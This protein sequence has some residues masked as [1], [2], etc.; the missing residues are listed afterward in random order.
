M[1]EIRIKTS[2]TCSMVSLAALLIIITHCTIFIPV[3]FDLLLW[4]HSDMGPLNIKL[5]K[6]WMTE[7]LSVAMRVRVEPCEGFHG[8]TLRITGDWYSWHRCCCILVPP[9]PHS[10]SDT[11]HL[12]GGF[13]VS[14]CNFRETQ[15]SASCFPWSQLR[16]KGLISLPAFHTVTVLREEISHIRFDAKTF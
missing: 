6:S 10:S 4:V 5:W 15:P 3:D 11:K 9:P 12:S 2:K 7:D 8:S 14:C 13:Q 16:E 1:A